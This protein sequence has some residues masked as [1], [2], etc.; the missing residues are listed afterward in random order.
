MSTIGRHEYAVVAALAVASLVAAALG[1]RLAPGGLHGKYWDNPESAGRPVAEATGSMPS[2]ADVLRRLPANGGSAEWSGSLRVEVPGDHRFDLR[3]GEGARL[4]INGVRVVEITGGHAGRPTAGHVTLPAGIHDVR[5]RHVH[6]GARSAFALHWTQPRRG[7]RPLEFDDVAPTRE[8]ALRR[9][10][11]LTRA[12]LLAVPVVWSLLFLYVPAKV[13]AWLAWR[14]VR[15]STPDAADRR[16]LQVVL[17]AAAVL[18][19][20]GLWAGLVGDAWTVDEMRA[21]LVRDAY[22]RGFSNG[23][24]DKYP[25]M[26]YAV[27]SIPLS[28]FEVAGWLSLVPVDSL[29]S[30]AAQLAAMRLVSVLMG[31]GC[32]VTAY[33]CAVELNGARRALASV[34]ALLLTPL[35]FYYSKTANLDVPSLFWFGW[36][37]LGFIR[38]IRHNRRAD[39]ALLGVAAA[40]AVATKDQQYANLALLPLAVVLVNARQQSSHTWPGRLSLALDDS[41]IWLGGIAALAASVLLHNMI[42]NFSGFLAHI[43][44]LG[45]FGTVLP[46]VPATAAG[47]A[48]LTWRTG[49]LFRFGMGWPLVVLAAIGVVRAV[50]RADRRWWLWLLLV[51]L[52][53]HLT[54]TCVTRYVCDRYLFGGIYVL[55]LFAG[56]SLSDLG[57][58]PRKRVASIVAGAAL[59]YSLL[60]AAS[61]NVMTTRDSRYEVRRWVSEHAPEGAVVGL[62]GGGHYMPYLGPPAVTLPVEAS[63]EDLARVKPGFLVVNAR[64]AVRYEARP[65]VRAFLKGLDDGSLGYEEVFRHRTPMPA[66]ALLQYEAPFRGTRE[67]ELTNLDKVNPEMV[68]YRRVGE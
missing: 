14:E 59:A 45:S 53:F 6:A 37:V 62:L 9:A 67:S 60:Y 47:Y 26:H 11:P 19:L 30:R 3:S 8:A 1:M 64:N 58:W 50:V 38:I 57:D 66:W 46:I 65:P 27:L 22:L 23:W 7:A 41:R 35:F 2:E 34:L 21:D 15:R 56:A 4:S 42:F 10:A 12:G 49:E 43:K 17:L 40:A 51:P 18:T 68:I 13:V 33:L 25:L 55:A 32:L 29:A 5:V 54:F 16:P 52:S 61:I 28:A 63:A 36:A 48:E 39:Y 31:L 24:H 20:W 44:V